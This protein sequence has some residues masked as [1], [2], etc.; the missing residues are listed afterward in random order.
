[1][2]QTDFLDDVTFYQSIHLD[3]FS[4][5]PTGLLLLKKF[6][7]GPTNVSILASVYNSDK[8]DN[9][10]TIIHSVQFINGKGSYTTYH[11]TIIGVIDE[12]RTSFYYL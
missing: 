9:A 11:S 12:V 10:D 4:I 3:L 1:M 8:P 5:T 6:P 7:D 2:N